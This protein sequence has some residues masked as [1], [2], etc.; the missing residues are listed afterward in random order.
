MP[1]PMP[2]SG[3]ARVLVGI[4]LVLGGAGNEVEKLVYDEREMSAASPGIVE[5]A[6]ERD[7]EGV[8]LSER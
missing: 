3:N 8:T 4:G 2:P 6:L 7:H 5:I 1:T